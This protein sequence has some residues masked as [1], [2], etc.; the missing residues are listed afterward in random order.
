[1][2]GWAVKDYDIL[3]V[4]RNRANIEHSLV[5]GWINPLRIQYC[6]WCIVVS[7]GIGVGLWYA[8]IGWWGCD[9]APACQIFG[10]LR[11][12]HRTVLG[13]GPRIRQLTSIPT[14]LSRYTRLMLSTSFD[15]REANLCGFTRQILVLGSTRNVGYKR[16]EAQKGLLISVS[17]PGTSSC[18][19]RYKRE[20]TF[21]KT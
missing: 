17:I 2:T 9:W 20:L 4:G 1:M 12:V 13:F 10:G 15:A 5:A 16:R 3:Q 6:I 19:A 21:S 8:T 18:W 14:F 11:N 7:I